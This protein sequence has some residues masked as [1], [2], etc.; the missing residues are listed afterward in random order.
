MKDLLE[1]TLERSLEY[2]ES[3]R[4]RPVS[5]DPAAVAGLKAFD[6]PLQQNPIDP[7][8]VVEEL[9]R[10]ARRTQWRCDFLDSLLAASVRLRSRRIGSCRHGIKTRDSTTRRLRLR[11][12]ATP[13]WHGGK[14]TVGRITVETGTAFWHYLLVPMHE[15]IRLRSLPLFNKAVRPFLILAMPAIIPGF[16]SAAFAQGTSTDSVATPITTVTVTATRSPRAVIE[17][18]SPVIVVDGAKIH[19]A[20]ANGSA[21]LLREYPGVDITGSGANQGR[22]IIRGQ[23]GQRILLLED[24][25]RLNNTRRQQDFGELPAL[26]GL[27]GLDRIEVVRGPASVLYGTD[28]IG[29]VINLI[30]ASPS[31]TASGPRVGGLLRYRYSSSDRQKRPSGGVNAQVGRFSFSATGDYRNAKDYEAPAGTFGKLS[32]AKDTRVNG[33]GVKDANVA[34]QAAAKLSANQEL[35]VRYSRYTASDAAFGFVSN[36]DLGTPKAA[37]VDIRYPDQRYAKT[38]FR[39]RASSLGLPFADRSEIVAYTSGNDRSLTLNVFIP[40]GPGTPPGAGVSVKS[41]NV[42]NLN[43]VGFRAEAAKVFWKQVFTYGA[44][45]FRD[46]SNNTDSSVTTVLGFGPP[47]PKMNDTASTPNASFRSTGLF[48]QTEAVLTDRLSIV[49]GMR[50]QTVTTNTRLTPKISAPLVESS[51]KAVVAAGNALFRVAGNVNLIASVGRA[52]RSPNLIERFFNGA[53]PEGNG[54]Q[55]RNPDLKAESSIDVDL[56]IKAGFRGVYGEAFFFRNSISNGIRIAPTGTKVGQFAA[57]KNVN[58]DRIRDSGVELSLQAPLSAGF[59]PG[60]SFT[61]IRSKNVLNPLNPV[62]DSYS[63]KVTG[64]LGWKNSS[65]RFWSE[66]LVRANGKRKDVS[67]GT[68]PIGPILP[69]F[70]VHSVRGSAK[71]FKTGSVSHS[72]NFAVN[73]LT[74]RLYAE[75]S[76]ASF[77]RPEPKRSAAVS[78]TTTF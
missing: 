45:F 63:S 75:F 36:T 32:L 17:T 35:S 43:T 11:S 65:G 71:L 33:T 67:L 41:R 21:E 48:A 55:L 10:V 3:L 2:L 56:G 30:N 6:I 49:S 14:H 77:F 27:D 39:Y 24:G 7:L 40:F 47:R 62:G 70:T 25:V 44:D 38:S 46:R 13:G 19:G 58:V 16:A 20:L 22:P 18:A 60:F 5:P 54:Y 57:F 66:Y 28:A 31:F 34:V 69:A 12:S 72:L 37:A 15:T 64:S 8:N 53:T 9:D 74:N 68:S 73:N 78:W 52:F 59:N 50:W 76:N 61:K 29:G 51:D 26:V 23:R 4:A 1:A 42:T